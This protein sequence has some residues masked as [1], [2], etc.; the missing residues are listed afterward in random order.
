MEEI[1]ALAEYLGLMICLEFLSVALR[2]G[3]Q[4][5]ALIF[6]G[7]HHSLKAAAA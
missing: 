3:I 1:D 6:F 4:D 2:V 7:S 5:A